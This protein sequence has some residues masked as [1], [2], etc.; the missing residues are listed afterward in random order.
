[1]Q[2]PGTP[3]ILLVLGDWAENAIPVLDYSE[4]ESQFYEITPASQLM[5]ITEGQRETALKLLGEGRK[6]A[7]IAVIV[8]CA[9]IT[10]KRLK[11]KAAEEGEIVKVVKPRGRS[12]PPV[13]RAEFD[14]AVKAY[15]DLHP[16]ASVSAVH[17]EMKK[18]GFSCSPTTTW[19]A[20]RLSHKPLKMV[21]CQK[22]EGP[23]KRQ[24]LS[25]AQATKAKVKLGVGKLKR[26]NCKQTAAVV[27]ISLAKLC[28]QDESFFT[29]DEGFNR[30]N[31]RVWTNKELKKAEVLADPESGIR[32]Q[33]TQGE[34]KAGIMVS[35]VLSTSGG[36][37]AVCPSGLKIDS[38]VWIRMMES[39]VV[40]DCTD[41]MGGRTDWTVIID[42]APSHASK[43]ARKFYSKLEPL[44]PKVLFQSARSPDLNACDWFLWSAMKAKLQQMGRA[45][46]LMQLRMNIFAAFNQVMAEQQ[47]A[48][49]RLGVEFMRRL[50]MVEATAG[51]HFEGA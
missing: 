36:R 35:A 38:G 48:I 25:Y 3:S 24:R 31:S 11:K 1:M 45:N 39:S 10:I 26:K 33:S 13:N 34:Q 32:H 9:P 30:Q 4:P 20:M 12:M 40:G 21:Q 14:A 22:L 23:Q 42:Q 5:A 44:G 49:G 2:S 51:G 16:K 43:E 37:L 7:K 17:S 50:D 28:W 29:L 15:V 27:G 6:I 46:S 19:R 18:M 41:L 8:G 47:D